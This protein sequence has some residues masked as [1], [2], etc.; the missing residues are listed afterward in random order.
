MCVAFKEKNHGKKWLTLATHKLVAQQGTFSLDWFVTKK[1]VRL[2]APIDCVNGAKAIL[3]S[4]L[5]VIWF[6]DFSSS[7]FQTIQSKNWSFFI[8][9]PGIV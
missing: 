5:V 2:M 9:K 6:D 1:K 4:I 3:K 8:A 7:F